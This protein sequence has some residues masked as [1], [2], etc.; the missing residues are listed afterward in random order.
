MTHPIEIE[1]AARY[2]DEP[3]A[4]YYSYNSDGQDMEFS[5]IAS[6][7]DD[8]GFEVRFCHDDL[9]E[10]LGIGKDH[11]VNSLSLTLFP[12][13]VAQ[14]AGAEPVPV[15]INVIDRSLYFAT[16]TLIDPQYGGLQW[17]DVY[18]STSDS[19]LILLDES[20]AL[21]T[22]GDSEAHS[23]G[24]IAIR[25]IGREPSEEYERGAI[26]DHQVS[27]EIEHGEVER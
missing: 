21:D 24:W 15:I 7:Q 11:S 20:I 2:A 6:C 16:P 18:S 17:F 14:P 26:A 4:S 22:R 12:S 13:Q 5:G 19:L 25:D 3:Y 9:L 8:E 23:K 27:H 1:L 10:F